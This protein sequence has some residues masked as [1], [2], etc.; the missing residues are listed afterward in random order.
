MVERQVVVEDPEQ[1]E[2]DGQEKEPEEEVTPP[3]GRPAVPQNGPLAGH[4]IG[5]DLGGGGPSVGRQRQ[6]VFR[7]HDVVGVGDGAL[8]KRAPV[9]AELVDQGRD[10][11]AGLEKSLLAPPVHRRQAQIEHE[12]VFQLRARESQMAEIVEHHPSGARVDD[13]A[14]AQVSHSVQ[15][16]ED[17]RT[18]LL[19]AQNDDAVVLFGVIRQN[20]DHHVGV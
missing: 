15:E 2:E 19:R 16:R 9:Q 8:A 14:Q 17:V 6:P 1:E 4:E 13:V 12:R 18:G 20:G 10:L 5:Q 7:F 3:D 11:V